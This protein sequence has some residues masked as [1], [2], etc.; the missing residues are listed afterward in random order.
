[1]P[2]KPYGSSF[3]IECQSSREEIDCWTLNGNRVTGATNGVDSSTIMSPILHVESM[4]R[5]LEGQ[6]ECFGVS[7]GLLSTINVFII[8]KR[9]CMLVCLFITVSTMQGTHCTQQMI[10]KLVLELVP[11]AYL[12]VKVIR[13]H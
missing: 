5:S 1:M 4:M 13:S 9:Y 3:N 12:I 11:T 10:V 7:S 8:G 2:P 6:Y